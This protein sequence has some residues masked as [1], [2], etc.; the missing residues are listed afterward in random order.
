MIDISLD[1]ALEYLER[2]I[3]TR[4]Q[5]SEDHFEIHDQTAC[6]IADL[7]RDI[8]YERDEARADVERLRSAIK[9]S[10]D[11]VYSRNGFLE[12]KN[13][14]PLTFELITNAYLAYRA[15]NATP[16]TPPAHE[17]EMRDE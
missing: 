1:D 13:N 3:D 6:R 7:L 17:Q 11:L 2:V 10:T 14:P 5:N 12:L 9:L 16:A 4:G 8:V 15:T